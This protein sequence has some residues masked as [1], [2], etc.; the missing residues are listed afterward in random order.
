MPLVRYRT[1]AP[2]VLRVG[3][4]HGAATDSP[5]AVARR[6]GIALGVEDA[7]RAATLFGGSIETIDLAPSGLR[8][9]RLAAVL[10]GDDA[11]SCEMLARSAAAAGILYVNDACP[12]DALRGADC[13]RNAYH[14]IPSQAMYR[15][16]ITMARAAGHA[17]AGEALVA[18]AWDPSLVRFGADTLNTRFRSRFGAGMTEPAWGAWFAIKVLWES[19]LRARSGA[20][21]AIAEFLS[22]DPAQFD[23]YK[24]RP[25]SFRSWDHQLRQPVY[26]MTRAAAGMK[27]AAEEPVAGSADESSRGL[28]DRLGVR[29]AQSICHFG[30]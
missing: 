2:V 10:G 19:A 7:R 30:T 12:S 9:A 15:D 5:A 3:V 23:G 1:L 24:G 4:V 29:A 26:V 14:V 18:T 6:H 16:A 27:L 21:D 25:L 22:R 13:R 17:A 11:P 28:L 20:P 8:S